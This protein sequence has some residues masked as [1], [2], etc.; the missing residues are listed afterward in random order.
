MT[1]R[2]HGA[3]WTPGTQEALNLQLASWKHGRGPPSWERTPPPHSV[4]SCRTLSVFA[5]AVLKAE[6]LYKAEVISRA[7]FANTTEQPPAFQYELAAKPEVFSMPQEPSKC[8]VSWESE[9]SPLDSSMSEALPGAEEFSNGEFSVPEEEPRD[10]YFLDDY[11]GQ[12]AAGPPLEEESAVQGEGLSMLPLQLLPSL[13][14]PF[15]EV[16]LKLARLSSTVARID[17]PQPGA[18]QPG[19]PQVPEQCLCWA[20]S[21]RGWPGAPGSTGQLEGWDGG[22]G[23]QIDACL[24]GRG[25]CG[26]GSS[27]GELQRRSGAVGEERM[28]LAQT[29]PLPPTLF[30]LEHPS[31]PELPEP[32]DTSSEAEVSNS[33]L[34]L[35]TLSISLALCEVDLVTEV[36]NEMESTA[37][38]S[39]WMEAEAEAAQG[40]QPQPLHPAGSLRKEN[41]G[42][43]V[44]VLTE[45][46]LDQQKAG[47][48]T[49]GRRG[50]VAGLGWVGYARELLPVS[51]DLRPALPPLGSGV[52]VSGCHSWLGRQASLLSYVG[53]PQVLLSPQFLW[54][55]STA[56]HDVGLT[57]LGNKPSQGPCDLLESWAVFTYFMALS[58]SLS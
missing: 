26:S 17:V 10:K 29:I 6:V 42:V 7:E 46:L 56:L 34:P 44:A 41:V 36:T 51:T 38:P 52:K 55:A 35:S 4:E 11:L 40:T 5:E 8:E 50:A 57:C 21:I 33:D 25:G 12:A 15:A 31:P 22:A 2:G 20:S 3:S 27:P 18:P 32:S 37:E 49:G 28:V 47:D 58:K 14:D 23:Y 13:Q 43:E 16:E 24:T 54:L 30:S 39:S 53:C 1:E 45:E 48:P 9:S 19:A